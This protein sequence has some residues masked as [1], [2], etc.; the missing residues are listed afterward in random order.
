M[1]DVYTALITP[2]TTLGEVDYSALKKIIDQQLRHKVSGFVVSGTTGESPTIS[3]EE[4]EKLFRFVFDTTHGKSISLIAGT[5]TNDTRET[6]WLTALAESIGYRKFLIVVP[7]YNKPSQEGLRQHFR[8]VADSLKEKAS[9]LIL[10]NVPGRTGVS[11]EIGTISELATHPKIR[12]IKEA[13][14]N[15]SFLRDLKKDLDMKK[16]EFSFLSG[17]DATYLDFLKAGGM[18]VI[19]VS[20]HLCPRA[21]IELGEAIEKKDMSG[22]EKIQNDFLPLFNQLFIESNPAPLK[23]FLKKLNLCENHLRL[24]L[25]PVSKESESKLTQALALYRIQDEVLL[26]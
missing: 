26:K 19:S 24:P 7:Y 16:I 21:M 11:L 25:V 9:E 12:G 6:I 10:Y 23:W 3:L 22:A 1:K 14:G 17:D 13:S 8:A 20:S 5:G 4:K 2:F 18:G 15:I